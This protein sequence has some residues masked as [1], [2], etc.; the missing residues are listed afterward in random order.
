MFFIVLCVRLFGYFLK[1]RAFPKKN[2]IAF[3]SG[4]ILVLG[5]YVYDEYFFTF[6]N[7]KGTL[8]EGPVK[9]PNGKYIANAYYKP[10]GGAAGGVDIWVKVTNNT[11]KKVT[12]TV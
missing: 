3:L 12:K 8:Q 10:W 1:R 7:L 4:I 2:L 9:S 11:S 6:N 5:I